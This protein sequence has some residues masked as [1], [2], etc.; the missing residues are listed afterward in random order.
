MSAPHR[1]RNPL[2]RFFRR[3]F[4][5]AL[6]LALIAT[7]AAALQVREVRIV[8]VRRFPARD[9]EAVLRSALGSP[10]IATRASALRARVRTVPWVA[11]AA[12]RVSLDGVVTCVLLE[13]EPVAVAVDEGVYQF[14]DREGRLLA[15]VSSIPSLLRL[16]GFAQFSEERSAFLAA[17]S[18]LERAWGTRI[19]RAQRLGPHDVALRF[20]GSSPPVLADPGRPEEL[21]AARRV[22][23]AWTAKWSVPARLDARLAGRVAVLPAP[24]AP[25]GES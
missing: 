13:R 16:E 18:E 22:L 1:H 20:A 5:T 19:E 24:V 8:G 11:D 12:V 4:P 25:E 21:V 9:V 17:R 3:T 23:A 10:T 6:A 15:T 7:L 2:R 14:V